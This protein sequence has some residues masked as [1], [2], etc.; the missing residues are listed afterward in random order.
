MQGRVPSYLKKNRSLS[1]G[2]PP[3]HLANPGEYFRVPANRAGLDVYAKRAW[4][5][6]Q[7]EGNLQVELLRF[8]HHLYIT[9]VTP[10]APLT[11]IGLSA[12]TGYP[13]ESDA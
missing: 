2:E 6:I 10:T 9:R 3:A 1:L 4:G 5:V 11:C 12:T 8:N 7:F 13:M